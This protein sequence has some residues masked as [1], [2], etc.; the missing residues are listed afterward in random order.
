MKPPFRTARKAVKQFAAWLSALRT[1]TVKFNG[2]LWSAELKGAEYALGYFTSQRRA[3]RFAR[4]Y[5]L[6]LSGW[7]E[8]PASNNR[9]YDE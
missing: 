8:R 9:K 5:R 7:G 1:V 6:Y 3:K 2:R 4:D